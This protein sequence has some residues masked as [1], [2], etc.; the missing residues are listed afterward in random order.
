MIVLAGDI[1]GTNARLALY[2][3]T[4]GRAMKTANGSSTRSSSTLPVEEP[5]VARADRRGL[6]QRGAHADR[7]GAGDHA[8]LPGHR[9]PGREQ[10]LPRHQ[11]AL[12][13]RRERPRLARRHR[14]GHAAQRLPCRRAGGHRGRAVVLIGLGGSRPVLHGPVAVLGAGTG[15]GEALLTWSPVEN[16]YQ[17][18][19][20]EGGH[21]DMAPRTP[22]GAGPLSLPD[23]EVRARLL[24]EGALGTRPRRRVHLPVPGARAALP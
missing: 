14:A 6:P 16:R 20:S 5:P 22:L 24:R 7:R 4:R 13:R 1:G 17:V 9:R 12:G 15:L 21:A 11:P 18:I 3:A 10:H 23:R 19:P 2:S 8:R